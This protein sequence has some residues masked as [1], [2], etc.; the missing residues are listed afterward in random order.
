V[1][2]APVPPNDTHV[3]HRHAKSDPVPARRP[4]QAARAALLPLPP[5]AG[6][7]SSPKQISD[8]SRLGTG[9]LFCTRTR[10]GRRH[11]GADKDRLEHRRVSESNRCSNRRRISPL[12]RDRRLTRASHSRQRIRRSR[13][14]ITACGGKPAVP[15]IAAVNSSLWRRGVGLDLHKV[16]VR[17]RG[18][19]GKEVE[20]NEYFARPTPRGAG[21][22]PASEGPIGR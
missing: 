14:T 5:A 10:R 1:Y 13:S 20:V 18:Q 11:R 21:D 6:H 2:S 16:A 12:N 9:R 7:Q 17:S 4:L 19:W 3:K 8:G 15:S 22:Q